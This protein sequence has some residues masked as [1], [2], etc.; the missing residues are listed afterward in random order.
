MI[1]HCA[2]QSFFLLLDKCQFFIFVIFSISIISL[3]LIPFCLQQ[4]YQTLQSNINSI[5][6]H[7]LLGNFSRC[8][9]HLFQQP[10]NL[11]KHGM[12]I[13]GMPLQPGVHSNLLEVQ[14][15]DVK[16]EVIGHGGN[17]TRFASSR[18]SEKQLP[19]VLDALEGIDE[20]FAVVEG[21]S[22]AILVLVL[23]GSES[24]HAGGNSGAKF[25]RAQAFSFLDDNGVFGGE[26]A[27]ELVE[28]GGDHGAE[29]V[30]EVF[31][32]DGAGEHGGGDDGGGGGQT[33]KGKR[34]SGSH[35][36]PSTFDTKV[37]SR[38]GLNCPTMTAI[39]GNIPGRYTYHPERFIT[40]IPKLVR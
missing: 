12:L 33:G 2:F 11:L 6:S 40:I 10:F 31:I 25:V 32:D 34:D 22:Y 35:I 9:L 1:L 16:S 14:I 23:A 39:K 27:E 29:F 17:Q 30:G 26:A 20:L 24:A 4:L 7:Q 13:N 5:T 8:G 38:I 19:F 36:I 37:E 15:I 21:E 28:A 3:A 18:W